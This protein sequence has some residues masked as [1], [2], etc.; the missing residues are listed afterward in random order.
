MK[1]F[2]EPAA[3]VLEGCEFAGIETGIPS[4]RRSVEREYK[5]RDFGGI[6]FSRSQALGRVV[7]VPCVEE[8]ADVALG[9]RS[10][11]VARIGVVRHIV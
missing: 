6:Y 4:S 7:S 1:N 11:R 3:N 5:L 2:Q 10:V 8:G 9:V